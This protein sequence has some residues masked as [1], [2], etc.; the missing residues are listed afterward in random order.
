MARARAPVEVE[1]LE[2]L[3]THNSPPVELLPVV[4]PSEKTNMAVVTCCFTCWCTCGCTSCSLIGVFNCC[5][6]CCFACCFT[7][8]ITALLVYCYLMHAPLHRLARPDVNRC[9]CLLF[10]LLHYST[11]LYLTA[12]YCYLIHPPDGARLVSSKVKPPSQ[13]CTTLIDKYALCVW[14]V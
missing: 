8:C 14:R 9:V 6:I 1:E 2:A 12:T 3:H 11:L 5:F 10:Y 7:C 13:Q 4:L